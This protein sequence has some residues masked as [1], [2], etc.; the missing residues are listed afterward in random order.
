MERYI[1]DEVIDEIRSRCDIV[2]VIQGYLPFKKAV[3]KLKALCPFHTEKTPSFTINQER[4]M[5]HCFGCGKGGDV[6]RFV[7]EKEGVDFPNAA[8][9]LAAKSGVVIPDKP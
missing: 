9:I 8:H 5:Y 3:N 4:Q 6:F 7:M 2:D 1:P